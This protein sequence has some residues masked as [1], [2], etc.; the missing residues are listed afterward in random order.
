MSRLEQ[1]YKRKKYAT[2][3]KLALIKR[4]ALSMTGILIFLSSLGFSTLA[5]FTDNT[6][7]LANSIS[8]ASYSLTLKVDGYK[9]P[10][11]TTVTLDKGSHLITLSGNGQTLNGFCVVKITGGETYHT[12]QINDGE[13]TFILNLSTPTEITF[14]EHW[15]N[16]ENYS[17]FAS[18]PQ[19]IIENGGEIIIS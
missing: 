16:F 5:L 4:I 14:Y 9:T 2:I 12:A 15:G 8:S 6:T 11:R 3:K 10:C 19:A 7:S 13:T 18:K 17:E 1:F